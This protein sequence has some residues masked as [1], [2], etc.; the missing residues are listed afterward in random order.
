[1]TDSDDH[2]PPELND[3]T[4][5]QSDQLSTATNRPRDEEISVPDGGGGPQGAPPSEEDDDDEDGISRRALLAG[6]TTVGG[7]ALAA[8]LLTGSDEEEPEPEETPTQQLQVPFDIWSE[9]RTGLQGSPDHLQATADEM[10]DGEEAEAMFE[11]VRDDI[12]LQPPKLDSNEGF[13]RRVNGG[14]EATLRGAIGTPREKAELLAALLEQAGYETVVRGY[15]KPLQESRLRDLYFDGPTHDFEPDLAELE[16]EQWSELMGEPEDGPSELSLVD[17]DGEESSD[18]ADRILGAIPDDVDTTAPPFDYEAGAQR[19]P[20][21]QFREA[22]TASSGDDGTE[23]ETPTPTAT[24]TT[25]GTQTESDRSETPSG[26]WQYAD[27]FHADESFGTLSDMSSLGNEMDVAGQTVGVTLEAART[28]APTDRFELVSGT[29]DARELAGRQLHLVTLPGRSAVDYPNLK[30]DDVDTFVPALTVQDPS[31]DVAERERL[32]VGGDPFTLTGE[33]YTLDDT[34][35]LR[36]DGVVVE[37]GED[38]WDIVIEMPDGS[39]ST[40]TP[41]EGEQGV[42]DY[43]AYDE[44]NAASAAFPEDVERPFTT[45]AFLYRNTET[46]KLSLVVVN[47]EAAESNGGKAR[48]VFEGVGNYQW[49]AQDGPEGEG[50]GSYDTYQPEGGK[51]ARRTTANWAWNSGFTDGGAI[52]HLNLPFDFEIKHV[53]TWD[54]DERG[55]LDKWVWLDG[56]P[57]TAVDVAEFSDEKPE[58]VSIRLYSKLVSEGKT[59]RIP[60]TQPTADNVEEFDLRVTPDSYPEI[61]LTIEPTDSNGAPVNSLPAGAVTVTEDDELV[62]AELVPDDQQNGTHEFKY[63]TPNREET[64]GERTVDVDIAGDGTESE[65]YAVPD[66]ATDPQTERGLIGLYLTVTVDGRTIR[67]TLGGYDPE[68]DADREPDQSDRDELFATLWGEYVLSFETAGVPYSVALDEEL[69]GKMSFEALNEARLNENIEEM[70]NVANEGHGLVS[71][72]PSPFQTRLP[73]RVTADSI[74]YGIGLRTILSGRRFVFG[75]GTAL[76]KV[77]VLPTS[78]VRTLRSDDNREREFTLTTERTARQAVMERE[79][80]E[81]STA[82]LLADATLVPASEATGGMSESVARQFQVAVQRAALSD[83]HHRLTAQSGETAAFWQVDAR[84]GDLLGVLPDGSGGGNGEEIIETIERITAMIAA[85]ETMEGYATMGPPSETDGVAKY[86]GR[87]LSRLYAIAAASIATISTESYNAA[88]TEA[89]AK[90]ICN[91]ADTITDSRA[92]PKSQ[93]SDIAE[94]MN[95]I[96]GAKDHTASTCLQ[97]DYS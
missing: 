2:G 1:M 13:A 42:K 83:D 78:T 29:W 80:F 90:R 70:R 36:K 12:A 7:L 71:Q 85:T 46:G 55:G 40:V 9:L 67:R 88:V 49:L 63:R 19:V 74:T 31:L 33:R 97:N 44:E 14:P 84:T 26:D 79:A 65:T 54:D 5:R 60:P 38:E 73:D 57:E 75:E 30:L 82:S 8:F 20:V 96:Q 81:T 89:I 35:T 47:D 61:H 69:G 92:F 28:N 62:P 77:D 51:T 16:L 95:N 3:R 6:G 11:F 43:Y 50:P 93:T 37:E 32:T 91:L 34:G 53:G 76:R 45:V 72:L 21:V 48:M 24:E 17:E 59:T 58:S 25:T 64:T 68:L 52:G 87:V 41:I 27:L 18:L 39:Q 56:D 10:V 23:T 66:D 86:Y 22:E 15:E 4:E 94:F